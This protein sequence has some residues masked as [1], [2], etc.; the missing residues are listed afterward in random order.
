MANRVGYG[1]GAVPLEKPA[2][3]DLVIDVS[4]AANRLG[5]ATMLAFIRDTVVGKAFSSCA[6]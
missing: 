4:K 2:E 1:P 5:I 3:A 6:E